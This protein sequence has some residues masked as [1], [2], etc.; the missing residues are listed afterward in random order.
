MFYSQEHKSGSRIEEH[1]IN[2]DIVVWYV[3]FKKWDLLEMIMYT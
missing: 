1:N 3:Q 2:V